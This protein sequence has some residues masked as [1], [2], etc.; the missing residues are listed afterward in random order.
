L[1]DTDDLRDRKR[2][3]ASPGVRQ[4][5]DVLDEYERSGMLSPS[6]YVGKRVLDWECGAGEFAHAFAAREAKQV[7]AADTW[8]S[9]QAIA[10]VPEF[11]LMS[12]GSVVFEKTDI[13]DIATRVRAGRLAAFDLVFANTVTEHFPN[14][15]KQ[16]SHAADALTTGGYL[17]INHDN[18][19]HPAGCHDHGFLQATGKVIHTAGPKCW[20]SE[21]RC[22]VSDEHRQKVARERPWA[23]GEQFERTKDPTDCSRC[24]YYIRSQPWAHLLYQDTFKRI[25]PEAFRLDQ[26]LNKL[27]PFQVR[28]ALIETGF[29]ILVERHP[30]VDNVPP[31]QLLVGPYAFSRQTLTTWMV[32]VLARK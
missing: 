10:A 4:K 30:Q 14:L 16:L 3:A 2:A 15:P 31:E 25:F 28:Q 13:E 24:A 23:W 11:A 32:R 1:G 20:E 5:L 17:F 8:L 7:L 22:S 27:T 29:Q 26:T 12:D 6:V 9:Q 21:A 18:Y 19:Y